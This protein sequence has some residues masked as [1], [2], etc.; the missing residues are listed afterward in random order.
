MK[1]YNNAL[2]PFARHLRSNMTDA[3]Q[4]LWQRLRRKQIHGLQFYR[5]KPLL[6][7]IVDFFCPKAALVIE[8]DGSQ[9]LESQHKAKDARR[10][11]GLAQLGLR[12]LRF[13]SRQ[14]LRETDAVVEVIYR[15]ASENPLQ[16][17]LS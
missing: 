16:P 2:K 15:A 12:V 4:V 7:F 10:D 17:P 1:P 6:D 5:Q 3:E 14:V 13:D 11:Q 8:I 9:H